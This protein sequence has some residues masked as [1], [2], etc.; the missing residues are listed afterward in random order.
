M[1]SCIGP[2]RKASSQFELGEEGP[3]NRGEVFY[4][5]PVR[6]PQAQLL[7]VCHKVT[8]RNQSDLSCSTILSLSLQQIFKIDL[9]LKFANARWSRFLSLQTIFVNIWK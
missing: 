1:R 6:A 7:G 3:E 8:G 4:L 9:D 2:E 5:C